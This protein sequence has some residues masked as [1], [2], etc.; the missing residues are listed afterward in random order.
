MMRTPSVRSLVPALVLATLAFAGPSAVVAD[1]AMPAT[2]GAVAPGPAERATP[3][4]HVG[5]SIELAVV[6]Y[7]EELDGIYRIDID[8]E[9]DL[10]FVGAIPAEGKTFAAV[11][12]AIQERVWAYYI[13]RPEVVVRPL[14]NITVLGEVR[15]PGTFDISGGEKLSTLIALAGG[16][17]EKA[18]LSKSRVTRDGEALQKDLTKALERGRT[19]ED[20]GIA[21]GDV[22]YVP[23]KGWWRDFRNWAALVSAVS[24]S[25][26]VYDRIDDN[27]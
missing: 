23:E 24:L 18:L 2:D 14:Y 20:I 17:S 15:R 16:T 21:S 5:D 25:V 10:P 4:F 9:L 7:G 8:G 12:A 3:V 22:V 13:N 27:N 19:I 6:G 11:R 1:D 26:A